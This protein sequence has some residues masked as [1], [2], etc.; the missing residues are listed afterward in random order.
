MTETS[1]IPQELSLTIN[2]SKLAVAQRP[3]LSVFEP[4]LR[5]VALSDSP[6]MVRALP[7]DHDFFLERLHGLSRR[8]KMP[9]RRCRD[10]ADT[11]ILLDAATRGED[12]EATLGTWALFD[13]H[14][15]TEDHQDKLGS[16]LEHLDLARLHGRLRHDRIPRVVMFAELGNRAKVLNRLDRRLSYFTLTVAPQESKEK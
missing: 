7:E 13:V 9:V 14:L 6:I 2:G 3:D 16:L 15:W 10:A 11:Q 8:S 1:T 4:A 12:E 5:S